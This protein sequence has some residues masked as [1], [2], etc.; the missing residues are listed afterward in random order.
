MEIYSECEELV[1]L[2]EK[3]DKNDLIEE[4]KQNE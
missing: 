1:K 4:I 3:S 2:W